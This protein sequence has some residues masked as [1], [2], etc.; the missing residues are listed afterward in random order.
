MFKKAGITAGLIGLAAAGAAL[1]HDEAGEKISRTL[2]LA[3]FDRIKVSGVYEL[4]V[5]VGSDFSIQLSGHEDEMERVEATV[6]NGELHLGHKRGGWRDRNDNNDHGVEAIITMPS[7]TGLKVSG[8]VDGEIAGVDVDRFNISLSGVGD[9]H[10][11]GECGDLDANVSGVGDLDARDLECRM[12]DVNVSGVGSA[13][14]FASEEVDADISGMGD[15]DIYGSP[16]RVSKSSGMFSDI[17][18]H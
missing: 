14:V 5:R 2:D 7:L 13:A 9:I 12:V 10:I 15:I 11:A 17:N 4:D 6:K 16:K 8:V 18:I 3:G 1:A